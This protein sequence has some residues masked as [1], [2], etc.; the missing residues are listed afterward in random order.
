MPPPPAAPTLAIDEHEALGRFRRWLLVLNSSA[1]FF[2]SL[3][4]HL[5]IVIALA[6][7]A[8]LTSTANR[9]LVIRAAQG[10]DSAELAELTPTPLEAESLPTTNDN[11]ANAEHDLAHS[12]SDSSSPEQLVET[13]AIT[14][15]LLD[16]VAVKPASGLIDEAMEDS[17]TPGGRSRAGSK[18][19]LYDDSFGGM[20]D[21]AR[22][23]GLDIVIAFDSTGSMGGEIAVVKQ[24]IEQIGT[25]LLKKIPGTRIS[26]CTYK[27]VSD[28][29]IVRGVPLTGELSKLTEFLG[30]ISANGGGDHEEAVQAGLNYAT[31]QLRFREDARKVV[32]LFGD[33]PPHKADLRACVAMA[34]QFHR[35]EHGIIT[36]ITVRNPEPLPEFVAISR[37]GG[38]SAFAL[39]DTNKLMEELVVQVFGNKHRKDAV[40]FFDLDAKP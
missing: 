17:L 22:E 9:E 3:A 8:F 38:G 33:A 5:A 1:G 24:R 37:A 23:N 34:D 13:T 30:P 2:A 35:Y 19:G 16:N 27:D 28:E 29:Y 32:L 39:A 40:K 10:D 15:D 25:S 21:Y 36:T 6:Q 11:E 14:S 18:G 26:F 31:K 20:I 12:A 4:L 7:F